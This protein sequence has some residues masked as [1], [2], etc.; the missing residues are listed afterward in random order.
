MLWSNGQ[1]ADRQRLEL[2]SAEAGLMVES[3][4]RRSVTSTSQVRL[5]CD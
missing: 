5:P 2:F 3:E 1:A 4:R